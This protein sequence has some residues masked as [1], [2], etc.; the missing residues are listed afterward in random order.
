M[1]AKKPIFYFGAV[2]LSIAMIFASASV[3]AIDTKNINEPTLVYG[4]ATPSY[5]SMPTTGT[6]KAKRLAQPLGT[7]IQ[8]TSS[9]EDEIEPAIA[10]DPAVQHLM[11]YTYVQ[12]VSENDIVWT[13]S[14]DGGQS[15]DPGVIYDIIGIESHPALSYMGIETSFTG[16]IQGDIYEGDGAH[17]YRFL[18]TD[19]T[20]SDSYELTFWDW[21]A[22]FPYKDRLIPDIGGYNLPGKAWWYGVIAC[23]GT[24][25]VRID[26]PIFN[27][28]NYVDEGNG[29][30]SYWDEYQGCMNAA[31]DVDLS[32]GNWYSVFDYLH[33]SD[34]DLLVI[35]GGCLDTNGDGYLDYFQD[36]IMGDAENTTYPA[37][38]AQDD[39]VMI[40]AQTNEFGS[41]DI[42]CY[43]S[44]DAGSTWAETMI[45]S[46]AGTDEVSPAIVVY[47]LDATCTFIKDGDLY[48]T[49]TTDGGA[50]WSTPEQVND[51]D[52]T[53]H[54][55]FRNTDITTDGAVIWSDNKNGNLDLYIDN[56]GGQALPLIEIESIGGGFGAKATIS[57]PGDVD[58]TN[59]N[60]SITFDG[61]II[62]IGKE[63]TGVISSLTAG[64][65]QEIKTGL[66]FG[67]GK[68]T[69]TVAVES[70]EGASDELS[71]EDVRVLLFFVLGL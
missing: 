45:T 69:I 47:G 26:M 61:G 8:V 22:S 5:E 21:S 18:C 6:I 50:T 15:W 67:F 71:A 1:N 29:W 7:D 51:D 66:I 20:D 53:V 28:A 65:T 9:L 59:I 43:Y 12:D 33:G 46:D 4:D 25:D 62:I 55:T 64:A 56:V 14:V 23:V 30:S 70:A 68:P 52:G 58:L 63:K 13:F 34:W 39:H 16:T 11:A 3:I 54:D 32:N 48:F 2:V 17:Q 42:I 40:V 24:R 35:T 31:V 38:G 10:V 60:W 19:P 27:Y 44:D 36:F 49:K 57:N 41:E 37:I